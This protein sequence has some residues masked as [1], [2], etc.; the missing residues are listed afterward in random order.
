MSGLTVEKGLNFEGF[1][2][3]NSGVCLCS[4]TGVYT[5]GIESESGKVT[6]SGNVDPSTLINKL[7]KKGKHAELW[8]S[9][10][11]K[12]NP[13]QFLDQFKNMQIG[14]N[15]KGGNDN[16]GKGVKGNNDINNQMQIKGGNL[17]MP[18]PQQLQQLKALQ[19]LKM[20]PQFKDMKM[21]MNAGGGGFGGGDGNG[22]NN[23]KNVKFDMPDEDDDFTD[24]DDYDDDDYDDD[25]EE[26]DEDDDD[27]FEEKMDNMPPNKMKLAMDNSGGSGGGQMPK[28]MQF[29]NGR[30]DGGGGGGMM[31]QMGMGG[32]GN[33]GGN[34]F[35]PPNLSSKSIIGGHH[36]EGKNVG[37]QNKSTNGGHASSNGGGNKGNGNKDGPPSM[38][39]MMAMKTG[40]P[41]MGPMGNTNMSMGRTGHNMG[42]MSNNLQMGRYPAVQGLPAPGMNSASSGN[43]GGYFQAARPE[44]LAGNAYQQPQMPAMMMNQQLE[45]QPMMYHPPQPQPMNYMHH[46]SYPYYPYPPPLISTNY[47]STSSVNDDESPSACIVM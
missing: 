31:P 14:N 15:S 16:K 44:I 3:E 26:D 46:Q 33:K 9:P 18:N 23:P 1:C 21:P 40:F 30:K 19:D 11:A 17:G 36:Q 28:M 43:N 5:I 6:V 27:D 41:N 2:S 25:D 37:G 29:M 24:D 20:H 22:G 39:E 10:K 34:G 35:A 8:V 45:H 7:R 47:G 42:D 38:Q 13:N 4:A 12:N 32:G